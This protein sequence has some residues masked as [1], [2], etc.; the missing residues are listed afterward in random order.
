[1]DING[2]YVYLDLFGWSLVLL[3]CNFF[4]YAS[5]DLHMGRAAFWRVPVSDSERTQCTCVRPTWALTNEVKV[6]CEKITIYKP[7]RLLDDNY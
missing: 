3:S 6:L 2:L 7:F 1:M 4:N 5:N